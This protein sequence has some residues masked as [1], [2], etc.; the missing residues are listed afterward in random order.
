MNTTLHYIGA[1]GE[2]IDLINNPYFHLTDMDGMTE[3][4]T[5]ISSSTNSNFDGDR[6]NNMRTRPRSLILDLTIRHCANV[7]EAKRYILRAIKPKQKGRL[8][9]HQNKRDLEIE[10]TVETISMPRF[11][12]RKGI[13]MQ[14]TLHCSEPYWQDVENVLFEISRVID[15][16]YFPLDVGGLA[17]PAG[18]VIM[19]EYD[20]NMTRTYINDGDDGC[21][22]IIYIVA[23]GNVTNPTIYKSDGSYI[24]VNVDMV[25][26]DEV[27]INTNRGEKSITINGTNILSKIK[28]GSSFLQLDPDDNVLTIGSD[29]NTGGNV[30]FLLSFKRRFV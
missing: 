18:G 28:R 8:L 4:A 22:M 9:L 20:M 24:G 30:Y 15:M 1:N 19:G 21:G 10:G 6:I 2:A 26:G 13:I 5:D 14:V 3:A 29:D 11:N 7:E 27:I 23:T 17:F 25:A 16:H 12:N